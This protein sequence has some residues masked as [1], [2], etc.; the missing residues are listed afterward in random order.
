MYWHFRKEKCSGMVVNTLPEGNENIVG[1][2]PED[3][4]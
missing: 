3:T 2:L 4:E 1:Q